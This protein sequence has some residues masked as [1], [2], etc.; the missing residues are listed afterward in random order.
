MYLICSILIKSTVNV[1]SVP[2][3]PLVQVSVD[4]A[5]VFVNTMGSALELLALLIDM[6]FAE[7]PVA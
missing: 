3:R 6:D 2:D 5:L 7:W 1:Y 4:F